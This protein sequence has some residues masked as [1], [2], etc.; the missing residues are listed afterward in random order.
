ML[1]RKQQIL[2]HLLELSYDKEQALRQSHKFALMVGATK[3]FTVWLEQ[4]LRAKWRRENTR[5][6]VGD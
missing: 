6:Y 4:G 3:S 5:V 2:F 1:T